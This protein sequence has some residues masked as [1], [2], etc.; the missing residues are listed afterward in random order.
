MVTFGKGTD[1]CWGYGTTSKI[2]GLKAYNSNEFADALSSIQCAASTT[3]IVEAVE[4]TTGLLRKEKGQ[5][6]VIVVSDFAWSDPSA[7]KSAV[8]ELKAQ[9]PDKLCLHTVKVG[10][11][12]GNEGLIANI[13]GPADCGSAVS[14]E[15]LASGT[16]MTNYVATTLMTPVPK[17]QYEKHTMSATTLFDFDRAVLKPA[18]KAELQQLG[19]SIRSQGMSVGDIDVI[20]HTD[21]VGTEAYN[22]NLSMQRAMAVRDYLVSEGVNAGIIDVI[23]MGEADPVA[24]N[25]TAEG[26]ELNR[27]VEVH[28]G[29]TKPM[30]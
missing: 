16:A 30:K 22:Q 11:E 25:D 3:P 9:H 13:S 10:D 12:P 19:A 5:I 17:M 28:V 14:A 23:G 24:S 7:V 15:D 18:G 26:R 8:A 21:S 20:G 27:R 1:S 29:T 6:A 2:Y 4:A